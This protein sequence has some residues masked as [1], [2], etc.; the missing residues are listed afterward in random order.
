MVADPASESYAQ[1]LL[2]LEAARTPGVWLGRNNCGALL[3]A[4]GRPVRFGL[5]NESAAM[6]ERLKSADLIGWRSLVV[7]PEHVGLRLAVFLS[8]E[9]KHPGWRYTGTA[10]ERAQLAWRDMVR[11]AGGDAEFTTGPLWPGQAG[12][13]V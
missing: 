5:G 2:R 1:S 3:D 10:R 6:S 11:A 12:D 7:T 13:G 8:R 4:R 9:V